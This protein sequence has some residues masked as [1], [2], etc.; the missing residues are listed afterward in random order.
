MLHPLLDEMRRGRRVLHVM[1]A[2]LVAACLAHQVVIG[3]PQQQQPQQRQHDGLE[4]APKWGWHLPSASVASDDRRDRRGDSGSVQ[5]TGGQSQQQSEQQGSSGTI[6][7]AT[8]PRR[9]QQP[10]QQS[11][12][13][14]LQYSGGTQQPQQLSPPGTLQYSGGTQQPQQ[15]QLSPPGTLQYSGGTQ[16]PQQQQLSPPGTLQYS[17][18]TQQPQ[19]LSPPGTLQ[20]SGGTQQPQQQQQ[21]SPPG[22]LQYSG[23]TQQPQQHQH[24][25]PFSNRRQQ[26][27][28]ESFAA[29]VGPGGAGAFPLSSSDAG[30]TPGLQYA[31]GRGRP[32]RYGA[33]DNL[34]SAAGTLDPRATAAAPGPQSLQPLQLGVSQH[35]VNAAGH[36][37][38][39]PAHAPAQPYQGWLSPV[40]PLFRPH[41]LHGLHQH[42]LQAGQP[43]QVLGQQGGQPG[44]VLGQQITPQPA[45]RPGG[46]QANGSSPGDVLGAFMS[47]L[48]SKAS[49]VGSAV[50]G[51]V[52]AVLWLPGVILDA[53]RG[54]Q[55]TP[56]TSS[57][58]R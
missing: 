27:P 46:Q 37:G 34:D 33:L 55:T 21:L 3:A 2:A 36:P 13:G 12:P 16:Q 30:G 42:V 49:M 47:L 32:H 1:L 35:Q 48:N 29:S 23:G 10:Q 18:G 52:R 20:Y 58:R 26:Y 28:L 22:T 53:L 57:G 44:Q 24:Q 31:V 39:A 54:V 15:Q 17:G 40:Q 8:A 41:G 9:Q 43:G 45:Q 6:Q 38:Q 25:Q 56:T 14:T 51:G 4:Y 19:Q 11:P 50:Q 5:Y 7:Y